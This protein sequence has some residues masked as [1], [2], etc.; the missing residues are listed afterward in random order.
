MMP[1]D[2]SVALVISFNSKELAPI[3][4]S[5]W[6]HRVMPCGFA[7]SLVQLCKLFVVSRILT[8]TFTVVKKKL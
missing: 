5:I 3:Q 4:V 6:F 8:V 1:S 7:Y 2:A